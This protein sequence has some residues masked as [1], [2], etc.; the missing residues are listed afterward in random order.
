MQKTKKII[1]I[2]SIILIICALSIGLYSLLK[3]FNITSINTLRNFI[4]KFGA[5][6]WIVFIVIQV[7]LSVPIFVIPLEDELW[8]TLSILLFDNKFGFVI[9]AIAMAI[10]SA[11]LYL[12]GRKLGVKIAEKIVGEKNLKEFQAKYDIKNKLSLPFMY[13]IPFI[14]H[15]MLCVSSGLSKIKFWYFILITIPLRSI[16]IVAIC[17]LGGE[18]IVWK[19]LRLFDWLILVNLALIDFVLLKK[20]QNFMENK[21]ANK[22]DKE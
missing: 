12:L 4:S 21:L 16:E 10:T 14:P 19:E 6:S 2:V 13:L 7:I 11:I 22:K 1:L 3:H 8:V 17:F 20:L 5:W 15:D 18:F 9:S